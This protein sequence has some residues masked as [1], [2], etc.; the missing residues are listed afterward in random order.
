MWKKE[1]ENMNIHERLNQIK[2]RIVHG[3][4]LTYTHDRRAEDLP[5]PPFTPGLLADRRLRQTLVEHFGSDSV[6]N[7]DRA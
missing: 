2:E 1:G 7:H 5:N 6:Q 3:N 4:I